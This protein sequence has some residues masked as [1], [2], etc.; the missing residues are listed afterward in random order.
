LNCFA[1]SSMSEISS[2][3]RSFI[4]RRCRVESAIKVQS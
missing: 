3:N 2:G 1:V 4:P